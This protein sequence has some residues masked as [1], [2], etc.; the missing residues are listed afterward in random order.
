MFF[1]TFFQKFYH[2]EFNFLDTL[3]KTQFFFRENHMP[4]KRNIQFTQGTSKGTCHFYSGKNIKKQR[5]TDYKES[6]LCLLEQKKNAIYNSCS[7]FLS[8][9]CFEYSD[10]I[11]FIVFTPEVYVIPFYW[12]VDCFYQIKIQDFSVENV[13][14]KIS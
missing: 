5:C 6:I 12:T 3:M 11:Q 14:K 4:K 10:K 9:I 8:T 2:C 1:N 7:I 13:L